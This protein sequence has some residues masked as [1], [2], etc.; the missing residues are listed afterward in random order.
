M[1]MYQYIKNDEELNAL[2]FLI[3]YRT[4]Q[5][6]KKRGMLKDVEKL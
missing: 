3:V 5:I 1:N 2:P 6:L 4:F